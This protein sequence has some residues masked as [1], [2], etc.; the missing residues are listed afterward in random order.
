M[1]RLLFLTGRLA[2]P[3]LRPGGRVAAVVY[4]P[5]PSAI[6]TCVP[7]RSVSVS[8]NDLKNG[9]A[10]NLPEVLA[11]VRPVPVPVPPT[12]LTI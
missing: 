9:M 1:E 5:G 7:V 10:L 8:S 3:A 6:S 4:S 11:E 12:A 2:E